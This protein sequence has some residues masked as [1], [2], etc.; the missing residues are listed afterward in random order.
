MRDWAYAPRSARILEHTGDRGEQ[1]VRDAT[2]SRSS[3]CT[4]TEHLRIWEVAGTPH[5]VASARAAATSP[6][7]VGAWSIG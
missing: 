2:T 5:G 6:I 4:D 7:G 3:P 1:R